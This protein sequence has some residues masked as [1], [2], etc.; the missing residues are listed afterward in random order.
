[1]AEQARPPRLSGGARC[2]HKPSLTL[3]VSDGTR[4]GAARRV[5]RTVGRI[6]KVRSCG[7]AIPPG[8]RVLERPCLLGELGRCAAP[9]LG[10]VDEQAY[11]TEVGDLRRFLSGDRET[12]VAELQA[13]GI[14]S[15]FRGG[16]RVTTP[17]V[18][19]V[20]RD[21]LVTQVQQQ[22]AS[23]HKHVEEDA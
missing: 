19:T 2:R 12:L 14:P 7:L 15:E 8:T 4:A 23:Q 5:L 20:V 21:V 1:M 13:R 3:L 16:F 9:C 10:E 17:E 6:S 18:M 22:L 11:A